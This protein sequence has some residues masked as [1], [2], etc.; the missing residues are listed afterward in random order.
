MAANSISAVAL[1]RAV[2]VEN[3]NG[4]PSLP[5]LTHTSRSVPVMSFGGIASSVR[6]RL[7]IWEHLSGSAALLSRNGVA[8]DT[9]G[10]TKARRGNVPVST[11]KST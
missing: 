10:L 9:Y 2:R 4:K 5:R 3:V 6:P 11:S 1:I 7:S 8:V